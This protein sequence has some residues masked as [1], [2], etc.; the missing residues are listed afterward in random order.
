MNDNVPANNSTGNYV[1]FI[2]SGTG[3]MRRRCPGSTR[4]SGLP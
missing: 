4:R 3:F 1:K 2:V